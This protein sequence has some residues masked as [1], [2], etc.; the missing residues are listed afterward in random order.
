MI[1]GLA[2]QG[3]VED[4]NYYL[5]V[6]KTD[7]SDLCFTCAMGAA[8]IGKCRGDFKQAEE[9]FIKAYPKSEF[10]SLGVIAELLGVD[11]A[12]AISVE[13]KHING[14]SIGQIAAWL[15]SSEGEGNHV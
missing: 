9:M 4:S 15:K 3:V 5:D 1:R 7:N 11:H 10:D 8:L 14:M 2:T 6:N 12:L 13:H